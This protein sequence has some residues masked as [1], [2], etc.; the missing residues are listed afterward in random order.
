MNRKGTR[1][2]RQLVLHAG[3][4]GIEIKVVK[5]KAMR[6]GGSGENL[7]SLSP[8]KGHDTRRNTLATD[9]S[10]LSHFVANIDKEW[11][12][13]AGLRI[14]ALMVRSIGVVLPHRF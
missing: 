8:H 4:W 6:S 3:G 11:L 13:H 7:A 9:Y 10:I 12:P 14:C 5:G 1:L 2:N